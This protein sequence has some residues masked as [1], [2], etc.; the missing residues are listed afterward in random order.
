MMGP[1]ADDGF[2]LD[3][4]ARSVDDAAAQIASLHDDGAAAAAALRSA[5]EGFHRPALVAIVEH[6][7][8]DPRGKELLFELVDEPAVRAV[9]SIHGIIKVEPP[10]PREA[11]TGSSAATPPGATATTTFIPLDALGRRPRN[12]RPSDRS[13]ADPVAP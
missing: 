1:D 8:D 7:R 2:D 10:D 5:I 4:A 12:D 9:L 13:T 6:L 3:A 11:A